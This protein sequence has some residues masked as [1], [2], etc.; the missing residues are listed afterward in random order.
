MLKPVK[1]KQLI[2]YSGASMKLM[3]DYSTERQKPGRSGIAYLK[4]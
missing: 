4:S 3:A 1:E 2:T